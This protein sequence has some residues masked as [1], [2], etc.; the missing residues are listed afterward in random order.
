MGEVEPKD[1][2]RQISVKLLFYLFIFFGLCF[3][4]F[5]YILQ[6]I[7]ELEKR[8]FFEVFDTSDCKYFPPKNNSALQK[9]IKVAPIYRS[10]TILSEMT[11]YLVVV[12]VAIV[13]TVT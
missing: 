13:A 5:F 8:E 9:W 6:K 10:C 12:C 7:M 3:F 1:L 11:V 2:A 4:H